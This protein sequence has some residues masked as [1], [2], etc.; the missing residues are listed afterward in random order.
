[1]L[2][3]CRVCGCQRLLVL[4]CGLVGCVGVEGLK[5]VGVGSL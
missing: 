3:D 5:C 1:M 2:E 4:V